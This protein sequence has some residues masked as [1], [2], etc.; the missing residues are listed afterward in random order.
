MEI[1]T[2]TQDPGISPGGSGE[3]P[4]SLARLHR[5]AVGLI[6]WV[7]IDR[8][9]LVVTNY[10]TSHLESWGSPEITARYRQLWGQ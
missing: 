9:G 7:A 6:P 3:A 10:R 8:P 2:G 4:L 1:E 5:F